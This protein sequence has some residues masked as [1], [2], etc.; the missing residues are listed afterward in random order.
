M[1]SPEKLK[2]MGW[3]LVLIS[4]LCCGPLARPAHADRLKEVAKVQGVRENQ[5]L[6]LSL[7]HI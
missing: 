6:G 3:L 1:K 7:I 2:I 5:L 4:A